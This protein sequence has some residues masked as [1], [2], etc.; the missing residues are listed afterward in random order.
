MSDL[1]SPTD[2][3]S[4]VGRMRHATDHYARAVSDDPQRG[5]ENTV[6]ILH[7]QDCLDS[8]IDLRECE[9]S[10]AM[11]KGITSP[12]PWARWKR[13]QDRPVRVLVVKGWLLPDLMTLRELTCP[14]C[15]LAGEHKLDC[16][17]R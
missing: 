8:G 2:I 16:G 14:E 5:T 7:S 1:V 3:E 13:V 6:Y 12:T 11:D 15:H 10:V 17:R 4:I 9:Y